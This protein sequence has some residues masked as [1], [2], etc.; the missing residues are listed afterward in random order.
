MQIAPQIWAEATSEPLIDQ[1][2]S[3][4]F[5]TLRLA[6]RS[7]LTAWAHLHPERTGDDPESWSDQVSR[8]MVA[9]VPGYILHRLTVKDF[10]D[11]VFFEGLIK[12][13]G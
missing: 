2:M 13:F 11:E 10:D 7:E 5:D 6:L 8:V 3:K 4:V 1:T 12:A 9:T